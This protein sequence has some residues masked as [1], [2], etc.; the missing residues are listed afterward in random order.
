MQME[1]PVIGIEY[2]LWIAVAIFAVTGDW[3]YHLANKK[4]QNIMPYLKEQALLGNLSFQGFSVFPEFLHV[5]I[6]SHH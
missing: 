1:P 5:K 4:R 3:L 6:C 2:W